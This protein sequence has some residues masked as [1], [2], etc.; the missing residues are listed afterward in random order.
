VD[1]SSLT[2]YPKLESQRRTYWN[3]DDEMETNKRVDK[4]HIVWR[5]QFLRGEKGN[6]ENSTGDKGDDDLM[7]NLSRSEV[8]VQP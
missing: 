4:N 1:V 5:T 6:S 8:A 3:V 7:I 2:K